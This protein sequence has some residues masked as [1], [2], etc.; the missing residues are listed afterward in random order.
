[1][2]ADTRPPSAEP[3]VNPQNIVVTRNERRGAGQYSEVSV[4]ALGM[5]PP[6]PSPVRKRRNTSHQ[7]DVACDDTRLATPKNSTQVS[8]TLLRPNRS[9]SGPKTNAPTISPA[10]PAP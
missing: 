10:K 6:S 7:I 4:T 8:R 5:A 2:C 1:M 9:A 3:T